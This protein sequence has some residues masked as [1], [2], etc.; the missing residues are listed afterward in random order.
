MEQGKQGTIGCKHV[1]FKFCLQTSK[2][3]TILEFRVTIFSIFLRFENIF[4]KTPQVP[5]GF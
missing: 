2:D 3:D 5:K 4:L 1:F